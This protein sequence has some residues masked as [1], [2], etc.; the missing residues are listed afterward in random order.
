M[1]KYL[2][3]YVLA[4]LVFHTLLGIGWIYIFGGNKAIK[5]KNEIIILVEAGYDVKNNWAYNTQKIIN[6]IKNKNQNK[7]IEVYYFNQTYEKIEK[8]MQGNF[9]LN[10]VSPYG[11]TDYS[12]IKEFQKNNVVDYIIGSTGVEKYIENKDIKIIY[13]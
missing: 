1:T 12:L 6:E 11:N 3:K 13:F 10:S 9:A 8:D 2:L 4:L 5:E 7:E